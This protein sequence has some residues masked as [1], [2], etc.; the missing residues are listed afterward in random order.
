MKGKV[1]FVK[2][3]EKKLNKDLEHKYYLIER[4]FKKHNLTDYLVCIDYDYTTNTYQHGFT[5]PHPSQAYSLFNLLVN[6][7][8]AF[9]DLLD[10]SGA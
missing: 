10:D 6:D 3:L 1:L 7:E 9:I 4:L 5:S 2:E 8:K